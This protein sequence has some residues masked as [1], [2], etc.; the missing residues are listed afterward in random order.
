MRSFTVEEIT[1]IVGG[2]LTK[3]ES[4]AI[5]QIAPP[6]LSDE[7]TLALALGEEEIAN[8]AN[9]KAKAALVPLGVQ[10]DGFTTIEVERPRL[11]MMKLLNLFYVPPVVNKD[12]HPSAIVDPTAKLGEN[13]TTVVKKLFEIGIM[14]SVSQNIDFDTL[15]APVLHGHDFQFVIFEFYDAAH[16]VLIRNF[17]KQIYNEVADGFTAVR[18]QIYP[19]FFIQVIQAYITI[20]KI[21][22]VIHLVDNF[23]FLIIFVVNIAHNLLDNILKGYDTAEAAVLINKNGNLLLQFL[24]FKEE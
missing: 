6:L 22:M 7:N 17:A 20:N 5:T 21:D 4:P 13:A 18:F 2:M 14:A 1:Q 12:I 15:D 10:I 11:A 8:L 9:S 3:A 19:K 23:F 16:I 24:Q